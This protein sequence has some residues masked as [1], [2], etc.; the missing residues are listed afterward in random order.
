MTHKI[1]ESKDKKPA[2][3]E[4]LAERLETMSKAAKSAVAACD[5]RMKDFCAECVKEAEKKRKIFS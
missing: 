3:Y 5:N 4:E 2:S 1:K